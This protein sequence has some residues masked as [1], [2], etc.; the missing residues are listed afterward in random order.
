V[1][2]GDVLDGDVLDG[3]VPPGLSVDAEHAARVRV[4]T[5]RTEATVR[6]LVCM[7]CS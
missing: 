1:L 4:S 6:V 7:Q 5:A 3:D 2:D